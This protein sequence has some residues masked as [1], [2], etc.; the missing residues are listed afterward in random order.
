MYGIFLH[1]PNSMIQLCRYTRH[2]AFGFPKYSMDGPAKLAMNAGN[3]W[4]TLQLSVGNPER[5]LSFHGIILVATGCFHSAI[6][7]H[8]LPWRMEPKFET[9]LG[10]QRYG[11]NGRSIYLMETMKKTY[12]VWKNL[13]RIANSPSVDQF[14]QQQTLL[15]SCKS[16][17]F[18]P[19]DVV[20]GLAGKNRH[21]QWTVSQYRTAE[22][23]I[24]KFGEKP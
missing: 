11:N 23:T 10:N 9:R 24:W 5:L 22:M 20:M 18:T 4:S 15:I 7:H 12:Q 8:P 14:T 13:L 2:G 19:P 21:V 17:G 1:L 6:E 16:H 3:T